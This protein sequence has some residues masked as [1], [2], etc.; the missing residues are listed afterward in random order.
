LSK[1]FVGFL[2]I[3]A[4]YMV[5]L[6]IK[7]SDINVVVYQKI[8]VCSFG[9]ITYVVNEHWIALQCVGYSTTQKRSP[10]HLSAPFI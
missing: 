4:P 5:S 2:W 6:F 8:A 7:I 10:I 3:A 9:D 1:K